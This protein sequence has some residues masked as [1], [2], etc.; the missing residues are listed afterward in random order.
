MFPLPLAALLFVAPARA[1]GHYQDDAL[2]LDMSK[3]NLGAI[4]SPDDKK[5]YIY[6]I[7]LE[8]ARIT[9]N[10]LKQVYEN[11]FDLYKKGEFNAAHDLTSKI[12]AIDPSDQDA[13]MLQAA[14]IDLNGSPH[15]L[16]SER[17]FVKDKFDEGM[18]L[19]QQGRLVEASER[20]EQ[21]VKLS[22][23][24]LKTR[25]WLKKVDREL[26]EEHFRRG[27]LAYRQH[28]LQETLDQW[29]SALVLYP[30]YPRLSA[31]IAKV[32]AE[33]REEEANDK[34]QT[35]LNLY[36]QGKT[37]E[38]LR[39]LDQ[40]LQ[41]G[42][43]NVKAQKLMAEI[44]SE[45]ASQHVAAGRQLYE[46]RKYEQAIAEWK[47][48]T[49]YGYDPQAAGEL[50]ARAKEQ[51]RR[52]EEARARAAEAAKKREE[53]AKEQAEEAAKA[54]AQKK[55]DAAK[56]QA[57]QQAAAQQGG[58]PGAGGPPETSEEARKSSQQ[59]YL[60]GVIYFQEGNYQK[61]KEEWTLALQL[62]PANPDA[63]AGLDRIE[64][65]YNQG[66]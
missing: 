19:Y 6:T 46:D 25:Y 26:A 29:Y 60:S 9:H 13:S 5:K 27:Q 34:L 45:M 38:S 12:L 59:H 1:S 39:T 55:A 28:R 58:T 37:V 51:M 53:Q 54:E 11:A 24:N 30:H 14:T 16:L 10:M 8:K 56:A 49:T 15:P 20:W 50:I 36:S 41:E 32:E 4:T 21:A 3:L 47:E 63:K 48:A 44:R 43:G 18:S 33:R 23:S 2:L 65:L 22:P 62:D 57:A 31:A 42:P 35:A 52:D 61:A 40:V 66:Q 17:R 64:Q 7:Q